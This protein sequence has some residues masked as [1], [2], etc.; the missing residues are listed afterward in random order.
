MEDCDHAETEDLDLHRYQCTECGLIKYYSGW[1]AKNWIPGA[2][3]E[4]LN[5]WSD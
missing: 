1:A 5:P 4:V 3:P 2:D